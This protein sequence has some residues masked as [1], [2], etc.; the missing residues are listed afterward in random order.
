MKKI[1]IEKLAWFSDRK[2]VCPSDGAVVIVCT[3]RGDILFAEMRGDEDWVD[4]GGEWVEDVLYWA[5]PQ[6]PD[7]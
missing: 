4:R 6:G 1:I 3:A 2:T 5:A 7:A